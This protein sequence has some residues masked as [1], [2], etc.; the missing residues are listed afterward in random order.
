MRFLRRVGAIS[1]PMLALSMVAMGCVLTA[2]PAAASSTPPFA[3]ISQSVPATSD[4]PTGQYSSPDMTIEVALAP[5]NEA[6][7][8]SQLQAVYTSGS[9]QYHQWLSKGQF[10][11]LYAPTAAERNAVISYLTGA[12]LTVGPSVSP[13]LIS[14]SGS[15]QRI[16]S[17]FRT[18]LDSYVDRRGTHYFSNSKAVQLPATLASGVLGVIGLSSTVR[19]SSMAVRPDGKPSASSSSCETGYPTTADLFNAAN[20]GINFPFGYGAGP[21][22]T[23]L[24]PSQTN[25][26][27]N[28]PQVGP[29]G[30]G[31]GV[32]AAVFELAAYQES[33][34]DAWAHTFYGP[35]YNPPLVNIYIDG[36]SASPICPTG[37]TCDPNFYD[38][39]IEVDADIEM[40]L[41]I[42]PDVSHLLVYDAP[43]DAEGI[44]ELDEYSAIADQDIADTVSS[45]YGMCE[46]DAGA[47]Y[48][49]AENTIFEQMALQGQSMFSSAGDSGAF[50]CIRDG[51]GTM[52]NVSDP[53][54]QPWVTSVGGTSL[55]SDNPGA[56][57]HPSYPTGVETVWNVDNLCANNATPDP[58]NGNETGG[59]QGGFPIP[60]GN[61]FWCLET[62]AGGGGSSQFWG[63]PFYQQGP[64]ITNSFTTYGNGTTQ[65]SLARTGTPCREDPDISANADE[66]TPYAE[67]C[68]GNAST[69]GSTCATISPTP[70]APGWFGVGGTSLSSPLWA[71]L[72]AD[73]D[74]FTGHRTGNANPL[75]Y[76][77]YNSD[78]HLFFHDI[79]GVGPAQQSATNNGQFPTTPGYDMATGIGTPNMSAII[80]GLS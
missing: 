43:N 57:Q 79:T 9:S 42:A 15:S 39:D 53:S 17:A 75:L 71:A 30:Q 14:A 13:F 77:W 45:S 26:I 55:E 6:A 41:D 80:T 4:T 19:A 60:S 69:L 62:G 16:E 25:S 8:Q 49:E 67:Y 47:A 37:D 76:S 72:I 38:N 59:V 50:S 5:G 22:C 24:T 56:N 1:P 64:G 73:R 33:D 31:A 63:R 44:T 46:N 34:I 23:G 74:G 10:D 27:Y 70:G 51:T 78:P 52:L 3:S 20:S 12:G 68:T 48:A 29:R 40:T 66:Y 28:A 32:T 36:G 61:L 65:C 7:L 21:G 58:E 18:N 11:S 2:G 35:G 54:S